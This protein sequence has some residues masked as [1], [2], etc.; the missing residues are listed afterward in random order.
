MWQTK[1]VLKAEGPHHR[2]KLGLAPR[3]WQKKIYLGSWN[4][5]ALGRSYAVAPLFLVELTLRN[6]AA[7]V[8]AE[9]DNLLTLLIGFGESV[10]R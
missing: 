8:G 2:V 10:L 7:P 9:P 4:V 5:S 6:Q 3:P 1:G